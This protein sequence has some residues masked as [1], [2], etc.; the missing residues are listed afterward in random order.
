M[1][2]FAPSTD[3][4]CILRRFVGDLLAKL[5]EES[6]S[7]EYYMNRCTTLRG[8]MRELKVMHQQLEQCRLESHQPP[9]DE[10]PLQ[11]QDRPKVVE[12]KD[13]SAK[14]VECV[15]CLDG[16]VQMALVPCGHACVCTGCGVG[17]DLCPIC[18]RSA[19]TKLE[20]FFP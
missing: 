5:K 17:L 9:G 8:R 3:D 11:R 20:L 16:P 7:H 13:R 10:E 15:I 18:R 4:P 6:A 12:G 1:T 14:V 19:D 2:H